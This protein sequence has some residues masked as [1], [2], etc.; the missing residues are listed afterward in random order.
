M[1]TKANIRNGATY[2][3]VHL[4]ANDYYSQGEGVTG[5][6]LRKLAEHFGIAGETIRSDDLFFENLRMNLTPDGKAKLTPRRQ[7]FVFRFPV[8]C[9]KVGLRHSGGDGDTRLRDA[10][11]SAVKLALGELE[12]FAACRA[13]Q[14]ASRLS[15]R[16]RIS[17]NICA[18]I[19]PPWCQPGACPQLHTHAVVANAT[20]D[21][22]T[23]LFWL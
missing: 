9:V 7:T 4:S 21:V 22:E 5:E 12:R 3:S 18:A 17:G 16:T 19:F 15:D 23:A 13:R 20:Y 1:F 10:H 14:G 8:F 2:L 11:R 6:W